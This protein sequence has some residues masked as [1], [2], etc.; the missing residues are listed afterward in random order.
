MDRYMI[1]IRYREEGINKVEK[2]KNGRGER[3]GEF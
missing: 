3:K 2:K 1:I